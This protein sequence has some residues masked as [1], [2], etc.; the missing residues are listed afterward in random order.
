VTRRDLVQFLAIMAGLVV[1]YYVTPWPGPNNSVPDWIGYVLI[2]LGIVG[3]G[4]A[5]I[6]QVTLFLQE[7]AGTQRRL[8]SLVYLLAIVVFF[9]ASAYFVFSQTEGAFS[10]IESRTDALYFTIT[11][12]STTGFGDIHPS[13]EWTRLLVTAHMVFNLVFVAAIATTLGAQIRDRVTHRRFR[14]SD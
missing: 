1:V 9:F 2:V 8:R 14:Q 10:G 4:A 13:E 7:E 12:L 5:S 11:I 3:L 6:W